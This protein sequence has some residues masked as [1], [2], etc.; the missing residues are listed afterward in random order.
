MT[1]I[2]F[3][4]GVTPL[5]FA[6]GAGSASR[7]SLGTAVFGGMIVSTLLNLIVTPVLYVV[8]AGIEERLG[9]GRHAP[10]TVSG[11]AVLPTGG[12]RVGI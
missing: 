4:F 6:S 11:E 7:Q 8:I 12:E 1:S 3:I 5:V 9:M 10:P 2:A